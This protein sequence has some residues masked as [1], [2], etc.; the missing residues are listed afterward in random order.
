MSIK[1][2]DQIYKCN[3]LYTTASYCCLLV[4]FVFICLFVL[5]H[6][7]A[8]HSL[9]CLLFKNTAALENYRIIVL[10]STTLTCWFKS[11]E[12]QVSK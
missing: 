8:I 6:F 9:S 10:K 1:Y 2:T 7:W 11:K 5:L 4:C 12:V 3:F